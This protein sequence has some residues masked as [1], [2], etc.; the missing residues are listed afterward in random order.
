VM[1]QVQMDLLAPGKYVAVLSPV[2][3]KV[4][5][6]AMGQVTI[7]RMNDE[8]KTSIKVTGVAAGVA[9]VQAL[10]MASAC[11]GTKSDTNADGFVD[12]SEAALGDMVIAFDNDLNSF[13]NGAETYPMANAAGSYRYNES[14]SFQ[15]MMDDIRNAGKQIVPVDGRVVV[16]YGIADATE[17]PTTVSGHADHSAHS[18]L[19][20]ACGTLVKVED[21]G[22]CTD[23][24]CN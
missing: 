10:H 16:V 7:S 17:L 22:T 21:S 1:N 3:G 6:R 24:D 2:N 9:H 19:P 15:R 11:P 20:V 13:L 5:P 8:F 14:A 12:A 23:K 18:S 4:A